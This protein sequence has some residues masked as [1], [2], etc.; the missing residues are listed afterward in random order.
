[1]NIGII[2]AGGIGSRMG[3]VDQPKQFIDVYGKPI[4]IHTLEAFDM[5][6]EIDAVAVVCLPEWQEDVRIWLRRYEINKVKW[7]IDAGKTRQESIYNGLKAIRADVAD[8]DIVVIHDSARPL[9]SNRIIS[10][11]IAGA[12][13]YKAV[14]TVIPASDTIVKSLDGEKIHS[15]PL[16]KELYMGQT[17]QSFEYKLIMETHK[18]AQENVIIDATDDCQLVLKREIPVQLVQ[19]DKLNFKITTMEDLVLLKAIVKIGNVE[20]I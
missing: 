8:E 17:P 10:D 6:S 1:M 3:L 11:N 14:D 5:H 18:Y 19:G 9:I 16:R 7:L 2:L 20:S 12:K 13:E 4:L 15:V